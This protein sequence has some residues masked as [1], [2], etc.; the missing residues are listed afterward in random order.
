MRIRQASLPL[1]LAVGAALLALPHPTPAAALAPVADPVVMAAGDISPEPATTTTHDIATSRLL[2]AG[3]PTVVAPLGDNQYQDGQLWKYTDP[4]GYAQSWGRLKDRTCAVVGNHD[5]LDPPPGPAGFLAY[6][7]PPCFQPRTGPGISAVYAYQL[8][9][10]R[11][12]V[13]NSQ[14]SQGNQTGPG[15][16]RYDPMI[17]WLRRDL[18]THTSSC[19]LAMW[20]HPRWGQ[21]APVGD[22]PRA[23]WLWN[24]F[25]YWGGDLVVNGHDHAYARL[26]AMSED[27]QPDPTF[28]GPRA[29][30]VGTGG[31]SLH[32]FTRPPHAGT[33]YRDDHHF[34][35]LYLRLAPTVWSSEFRRTDGVVA[36]KAA[37]GCTRN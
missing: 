31:D 25:A 2:L 13:L 21:G 4:A 23:M 19:K 5:Y 26:T 34:G 12:Y 6:F 28:K 36:D 24:V 15:C 33:R 9:S 8:G 20:H 35:V 27:G 37:A 17:N 14:C 22:N 11:V 30:T 32:A 7:R 29:I 18:Q 1:A 10:W 16:G 3:N